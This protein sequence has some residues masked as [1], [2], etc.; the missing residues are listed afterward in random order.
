MD[1]KEEMDAYNIPQKK[2]P[3]IFKWGLGG[4]W[5]T[6]GAL[7]AL[8]ICCFLA[9]I[10][11]ADKEKQNSKAE[12]REMRD[13]LIEKMRNDLKASAAPLMQD[14]RQIQKSVDSLSRKVDTIKNNI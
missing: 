7:L 14:A 2:R 1:L 8:L 12:E 5:S 6:A 13:M 4:G 3:V 9:R 10:R 11:E